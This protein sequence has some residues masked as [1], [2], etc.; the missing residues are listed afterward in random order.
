M[1]VPLGSND[2][3]AIIPQKPKSDEKVGETTSFV[4][5]T[6]RAAKKKTNTHNPFAL[7]ATQAPRQ[8]LANRRS[9]PYHRL[10]SSDKNTKHKPSSKNKNKV[11][12][13]NDTNTRTGRSSPTFLQKN[14]L[15]LLLTPFVTLTVFS[16]ILSVVYLIPFIAP[17]ITLGA[18]LGLAAWQFILILSGIVT[19]L[20]TFAVGYF[21][22]Q[23][24][25]KNGLNA[26]HS[27]PAP[28]PIPN[29]TSTTATLLNEMQIRPKTVN[30]T[31]NEN[32]INRSRI[33]AAP[34][35]IRL[36]VVVNAEL[37]KGE[38]LLE[39]LTSIQQQHLALLASKSL[40]IAK[41]EANL[42]NSNKKPSVVIGLNLPEKYF[43]EHSDKIAINY[44]LDE[45]KD[46]RVEWHPNSETKRKEKKEEESFSFNS[47]HT[48][49]NAVKPAS[50]SATTARANAD[51][52]NTST[53]TESNEPTPYGY[54]VYY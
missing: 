42:N 21:L 35:M 2:G 23:Q 33:E 19:P 6:A 32:T 49:Y 1:F 41:I 54:T 26:N 8:K 38:N 36:Y 15:K 37:A 46:I 17:S 14:S 30:P 11:N 9:I 48:L 16:L 50:V 4:L 13:G 31:N 24:H 12:D 3:D 51:D 18:V 10:D 29:L 47:G 44:L 34:K 53:S 28:T 25:L 27:R 45:A 5:P 20:V 52:E 43:P 39:N 7:P 40:H 22:Y